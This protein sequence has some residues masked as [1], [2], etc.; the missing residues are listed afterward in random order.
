MSPGLTR[1]IAI[2]LVVGLVGAGVIGALSTLGGSDGS[3]RGSAGPAPTGSP[4]PGSSTPPSPELAPF[5]GQRLDW[6]PCSDFECAT[7]TVPVDYRDPSGDT[8][9]LALLKDPADDPSARIGSLVVNPGG[10]GVPGTSYAAQGRSAFRQPL[11]TRFDVVGFDP[12]GTGSSDPVDCLDDAALDDFL[13]VDPVPDDAGEVAALVSAH[14]AFWRGCAANSD[15]L[16]GHVT[17][18]EAARDMDVLRSALGESTLTYL[19]ASYGTK[20][21]ATYADLFPDRVGRFVLDGAV[22]VSLSARASSLAQAKGF[23]TAL[24]SY[25]QD[26]L[27]QSDGC[28][29]GDTLEAALAR[30]KEFLARVDAEPLPTSDGDRVLDGGNAFS[31]I[32]LPLYSR[33]YWS[34]LS[35][36]LQ[37]GLDGDGSTLLRLSDAYASRNPDGSYADNSMEALA[38]INC[39]DD[40]LVVRADQV[41]E[42]L[43]DFER[44]SPTFGD[45]FAW[46]LLGCAGIRER[47]TEHDRVIRAAGAA[48][49]VVIGTTRDPA[50]PYAGAVRLAH[51]LES[52]VLVS[53]DGD[54]HTA[55]NNGNACIDGAVEDYLINDVVPTDGLSC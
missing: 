25:V 45:V 26:C 20:L 35:Q 48:P 8:I 50:T 15:D 27:A 36:A 7:L 24:R 40:P 33:D 37:A 49:I 29:L 16:V 41:P 53:R 9:D 2:L 17:T 46:G 34:I 14:D 23:E 43:A 38:V 39:L 18:V 11:L 13:A 6:G 21:G 19:G 31:G 52:G 5:Y 10:P 4:Q 28:F 51:Q 12:R 3:S 42:Q 55:Y 54:G 30:I 22:D 32:V 44:A 47:A 1:I